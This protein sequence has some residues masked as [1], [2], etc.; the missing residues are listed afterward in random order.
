MAAHR[1]EIFYPPP[2]PRCH[3]SFTFRNFF[4]NVSPTSFGGTLLAVRD[5]VH[6]GSP[7]VAV[8]SGPKASVFAARVGQVGSALP[9][10]CA[11][12]K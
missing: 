2:C 1:R 11:A 3:M 9:Q 8:G 4:L 10:G 12:P 5:W 7:R 6:Q